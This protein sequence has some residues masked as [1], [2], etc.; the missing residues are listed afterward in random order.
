M[1]NILS[2]KFFIDTNILVYSFDSEDQKK[3]KTSFQIIETALKTGKG[4]ISFQVVQEFLN[5]ACRKFSV[6]M[7][8]EDAQI[9]LGMVLR[10]LCT[11]F[12]SISL[13][14]K[15]LEISDRYRYSFYDSIIIAS[16][17]ELSCKYLLTEDMNHGQEIEG[18]KIVNPFC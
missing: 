5:V 18:L 6:P 16:A 14:A 9:Y 12:S 15:S 4:N 17:Q 8:P 1:E 11:V 13:Y 7:S 10:P 2:E 3:G